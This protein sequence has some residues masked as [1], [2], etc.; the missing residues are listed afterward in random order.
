MAN[1]HDKVVLS[2][3]N[4]DR[5][6]QLVFE[7]VTRAPRLSDKVADLLLERIL[8]QGFKAGDKLPSERE[9]G[10]QFGVSRTVIREATRALAAR[11]IIDVRAGVGLCVAAVDASAVSSTMRLFMHGSEELTYE[12][13]HEVRRLLEIDAAGL[14]AERATDDDLLRLRGCMERLVEADSDAELWAL[15]DVEF[16][17]TVC[18]LTHN[19]LYVIMLDSINDVLLEIRRATVNIPRRLP[20]LLVAH[21]RIYDA[22]V[23]HDAEAARRAMRSHLQELE[24]AWKKLARPVGRIV[25]P[26]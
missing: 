11:G 3:L 16:H 22:I 24:R 13:V 14:A 25:K 10:E 18:Q 15:G 21:E 1:S 23:A 4:G 2:Q 26:S 12:E 20:K 19:P 17:R 9:L 8:S 6:D 5:I 7:P